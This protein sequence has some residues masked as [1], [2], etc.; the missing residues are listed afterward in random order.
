MIEKIPGDI[1]ECGVGRGR[2]IL[3]LATLNDLLSSSESGQRKIYGYDSFAGFPEPTAE[4][5]SAR[6]PK[7]GEWSTSPSGK[8]R[9][10]PDFVR[11][12][13]KDADV[14]CEQLT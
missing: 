10:S 14:P 5:K 7:K 9:Y 12:I 2:S 11:Q 3:I 8:Y 6:N 4:D 13:M 1:V